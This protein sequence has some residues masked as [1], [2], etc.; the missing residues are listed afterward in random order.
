LAIRI[1]ALNLYFP[2]PPHIN[3]ELRG[4][5]ANPLIFASRIWFHR[6]F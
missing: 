2:F 1:V 5:P 4:M 3:Q 6:P